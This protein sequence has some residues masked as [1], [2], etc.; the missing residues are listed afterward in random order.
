MIEANVYF[1]AEKPY[2]VGR[3]ADER[4]KFIVGGYRAEVISELPGDLRL[5][6]GVHADADD[7]K[8]D[9]CEQAARH[10]VA[11]AIKFNR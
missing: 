9:L 11:D 4:H 3:T 5:Y 1:R 2:G 8:R 6:T 10:G 7:A